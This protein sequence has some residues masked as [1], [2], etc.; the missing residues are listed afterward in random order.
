MQPDGIRVVEINLNL[1]DAFYYLRWMPKDSSGGGARRRALEAARAIGGELGWRIPAAGVR[2]R[3]GDVH[4]L[5]RTAGDIL[6][7]GLSRL[8][9]SAARH[10]IH[11]VQ[12]GPTA[13][14]VRR[15]IL[16][17]GAGATGLPEIHYGLF[18]GERNWAESVLHALSRQAATRPHGIGSSLFG[19]LTP[20]SAG[21]RD[22]AVD[23][24]HAGQGMVTG[25]KPPCRD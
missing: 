11:L 13:K 17:P 20:G 21:G 2:S 19:G 12:P 1:P 24:Y 23:A 22:A 25:V 15:H 5:L 10:R 4:L 7:R 6:D 14:Q 8:L 16:G 18:M 9:Q 3:G